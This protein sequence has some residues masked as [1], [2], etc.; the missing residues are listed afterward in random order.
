MEIKTSKLGKPFWAYRNS[1]KLP[2]VVQRITYHNQDHTPQNK[3]SGEVESRLCVRCDR[4]VDAKWVSVNFEEVTTSR[5]GYTAGRTISVTFTQ[6]EAER[7]AEFFK[8][9]TVIED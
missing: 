7:L 8:G 6:E 2:A 3:R 4:H 1:P 5:S 9:E